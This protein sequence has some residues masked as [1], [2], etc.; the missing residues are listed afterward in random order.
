MDFPAELKNFLDQDGKLKQWPT[1]RSLQL[2]ALNHL[3]T[4]FEVGK[5]YAESEVNQILRNSHTFENP[6]L[7]RRDMIDAKLLYRTKDCKEY[8]IEK[9]ETEAKT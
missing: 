1:K 5:K 2:L 6:A 7:L 9:K 3:Y 8:W 4:Q